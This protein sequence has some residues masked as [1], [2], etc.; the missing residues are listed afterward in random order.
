V[1]FRKWNLNANVPDAI[2]RFEPPA[3]ATRVDVAAMAQAPGAQVAPF[4]AAQ[5]KTP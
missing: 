5:G 1:S 2:F 3:G 4:R